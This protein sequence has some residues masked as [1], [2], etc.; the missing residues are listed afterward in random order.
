MTN[1]LCC[2]VRQFC[3][4]QWVPVRGPPGLE[5]RGDQ[6]TADWP[7]GQPRGQR[8]HGLL[9]RGTAAISKLQYCRH[10]KSVNFKTLIIVLEIQQ[11]R[12]I[13]IF[14]KVK[15]T[16]NH[17]LKDNSKIRFWWQI[18]L[19]VVLHC[20]TNNQSLRIKSEHFTKRANARLP[21]C[22]NVTVAS[23]PSLTGSV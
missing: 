15:R 19:K 3:L 12:N 11:E 18:S 21:V 4:G 6:Q 7:A 9:D 22:H 8:V 5:T 23:A 13:I 20:T 16:N 17:V 1:K 2:C 14:C 10:E